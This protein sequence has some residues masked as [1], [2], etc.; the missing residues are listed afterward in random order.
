MARKRSTIKNWPAES[1]AML[2]VDKLIPY[3][4]N[5][6]TH[7]D[8]QVAQIAASMQEWGWTNPILIDDEG[9][10][11]AGHG[12]ILAARKL[13]YEKIPCMTASGWTEAQKR[14]YVIADNKLA[15][16]ADWDNDILSTELEELQGLGFDLELTGFSD[17]ELNE[18][19]TEETEGLT[20][21]DDVPELEDETITTEGD[22]WILGN[23]RLLCGE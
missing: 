1:V 15:M 12:R 10:V 14:A 6:R 3:A 17:I 23:H 9:G 21:P 2:S 11:I 19:S 18:Y 20:D 13:G 7:N 22:I 5:A 8:E 16:N 4:R